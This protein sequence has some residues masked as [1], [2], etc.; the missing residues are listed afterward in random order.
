MT[1]A[2]V[3]DGVVDQIRQPP[4]LIWIGWRWR[5]LR[6]LNSDLLA[7]HGW[8]QVV[9]TPRPADTETHTH[10][11]SVELV[12]GVP[13]VVW[14]Q[15]EWAPDEIAAQQRVTNTDT[16]RTRAAQAL[17]SNA[18]F[19]ALASPTNVQILAHVRR[20]TKELNGLIRLEL[21]DLDE[22]GDTD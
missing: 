5:D 2:H 11:R 17:V 10:D 9:Q 19:L 16:V 20:M 8:Y 15:R 21:G 22:I 18:A 3:T 4:R 7:A 14:T 6:S 12:G 13:T 1:Y